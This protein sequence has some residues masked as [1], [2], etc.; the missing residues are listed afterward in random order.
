MRQAYP[1]RV[2]SSARQRLPDQTADHAEV[3]GWKHTGVRTR[4]RLGPYQVDVRGGPVM[5]LEKHAVEADL[6]VLG[7]AVVSHVIDGRVFGEAVI[8]RTQRRPDVAI[9]QGDP[10]I[11]RVPHVEIAEDHRV[12]G[13]SQRAEQPAQLATT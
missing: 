1:S 3:V 13:G 8:V 2:W 7:L 11:L 9:G 5:S 6:P 10:R 12:V 4:N